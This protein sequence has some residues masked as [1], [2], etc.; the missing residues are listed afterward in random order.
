MLGSGGSGGMS[1]T[2]VG[3]EIVEA[4]DDDAD[5]HADERDLHEAVAAPSTDEPSAAVEDA[6]AVDPE[7]EPAEPAD[8]EESA[9]AGVEAVEQLRADAERAFAGGLGADGEGEDAPAGG[10]DGDGACA[11]QAT[12][13]LESHAADIMALESE[14]EVRSVCVC[15]CLAR[16]HWCCATRVARPSLRR[17]ERSASRTRARVARCHFIRMGRLSIRTLSACVAVART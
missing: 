8:E 12:M 13:L 7:A 11:L 5:E 10:A 15:V 16:A 6:A 2:T 9:L 1:A 14:L 4:E 17:C 3:L